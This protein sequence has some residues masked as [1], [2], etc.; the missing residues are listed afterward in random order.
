MPEFALQIALE[1]AVDV[2]AERRRLEK[3]EEKLQRD[4]SAVR[5]RLQNQ[6]F[7]SKAPKNVVES[8]R[9][10]KEELDVKYSKVAETLQNLG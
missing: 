3:E 8:L 6:Q 7:L 2:E 1:D 9:Q 4:I 5:A 10:R